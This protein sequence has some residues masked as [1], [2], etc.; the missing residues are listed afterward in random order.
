MSGKYTD[1]VI[2][3]GRIQRAIEIHTEKLK[4]EHPHFRDDFLRGMEAIQHVVE[5]YYDEEDDKS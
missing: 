3:L 2:I 1:R 4:Q 5:E